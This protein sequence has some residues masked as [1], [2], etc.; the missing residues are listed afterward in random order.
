[1]KQIILFKRLMW[2]SPTQL[3]R[4]WLPRVFRGTD[5]YCNPSIAA[6]I[7]PLGAFIVFWK[8]GPLRTK[9]CEECAAFDAPV[10]GWAWEGVPVSF[11]G[12]SGGEILDWATERE[13]M[14]SAR[15]AAQGER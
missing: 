7:P 14:E 8:P 3:T 12:S 11:D 5:E 4:W 6:V 10:R 2:W 13:R 15:R 1:M 9:P